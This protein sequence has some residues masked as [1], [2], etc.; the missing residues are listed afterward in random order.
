MR[1]E[2]NPF[3]ARSFVNRV[4][5][6]YFGVGIVHPVDDFSL[7]NPPSND[8]LLDALARDFV[9]N[10][11][12]IRKLERTI[13]NS[14]TY[15]LTSAVNATNKHDRINY[16]HA[17]VRPLM[18]EVVVDTL[19]AATGSKERWGVEAPEGCR[20]IEVGASR[21]NNQAV[22]YVF[23]VFGRPPRATACDCERSMDAGLPQKLYL[24]AD[25]VM[26][27]KIQKADRLTS[28]LAKTDDK[29]ALDELYLTTLTRLPTDAE[30]AKLTAYLARKKDRRKAYTDILWAVVNTAEFIFNH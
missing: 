10:K 9:K 21:L 3:F 30:R 28:I 5:G 25:P 13:L 19:D 24:M 29:E 8:K 17:Y 4:W 23:R 16:A 2:D 6:Q 20:A 18:A 22:N 7:A 14:R 15:Q 12:D 11:Y 1:K 27:D 26:Y